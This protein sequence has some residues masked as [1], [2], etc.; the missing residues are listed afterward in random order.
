MIDPLQ[1]NAISQ[2]KSDPK[3]ETGHQRLSLEK[4][5]AWENLGY[6]MFIHFGMST[7]D[8]DELSKGDKPS[9]FY[10]PDKLDVDQWVSI[11]RDAGMKYAVLTAKHVAGHCLWPTKHTDYQIGTSGNKTDVVGAFVEACRKRGVL[12]RFLLLFLGQSQPVWFRHANA[13]PRR[14][15]P[16][17]AIAG[18]IPLS[19]LPL[20]TNF[21]WPS[22]KSC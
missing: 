11:A 5:R 14:S 8:G 19:P 1:S 4:L 6:G 18:I 20:T 7:F 2:Q 16:L 15:R 13:I 17:T 10:A 21:N 22:S 9:T 12:P 3:P